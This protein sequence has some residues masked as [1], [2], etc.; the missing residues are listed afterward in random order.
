MDFVQAEVRRCGTICGGLALPIEIHILKFQSL[1][2]VGLVS[3]PRHKIDGQVMSN[4]RNFR[5]KTQEVGVHP[6]SWY[7]TT[8]FK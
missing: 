8:K 4:T 3:F 2:L 7:L 6:G 1:G 5:I